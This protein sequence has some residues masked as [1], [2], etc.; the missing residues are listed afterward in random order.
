VSVPRSFTDDGFG[1]RYLWVD[2]VNS[3]HWD[4]FGHV[5]DH[6]ADPAWVAALLRH[7]G[8]NPALARRAPRAA[9]AALRAELRDAAEM[10]AS[11][12]RLRPDELKALN[13]ALGE[14][15]TRRLRATKEGYDFALT[16]VRE[17]WRWIE[18]QIAASLAE[19]LADEAV[20]RLKICANP[21]CAWVFFDETKGNTRRWCNDLTCGNRSRVRQ[22]RE[23]R[24]EAR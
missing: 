3:Q 18:A 21:G 17:G 12:R 1:Q 5:S 2:L 14:P 24:A 7:W 19:L 8:F 22:F 13:A 16:P 11:G 23:R 6:L 20:R 9:L 10:I 15:A 4:G